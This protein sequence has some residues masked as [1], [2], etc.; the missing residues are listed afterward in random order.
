MP[1][2]ANRVSTRG[3]RSRE[4]SATGT[5]G[6][7]LRE[8]RGVRR[9]T[10]S[11]TPRRSRDESTARRPKDPF[12]MHD[13]L[14]AASREARRA[15]RALRGALDR[16]H[17][18]ELFAPLSRVVDVRTGLR[19]GGR[20]AVRSVAPGDLGP[21]GRSTAAATRD[22]ARRWTRGS[23]AEGSRPRDGKDFVRAMGC[24]PRPVSSL[25][26]RDTSRSAY[27][28][29]NA[30]HSIRGTRNEVLRALDLHGSLGVSSPRSGPRW[31]VL[32][33]AVRGP[34]PCRTPKR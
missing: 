15:E 11:N 28:P 26:P 8:C 10:S 5:H 4:S 23:S 31:E 14:G 16:L 32:P 19:R 29:S 27:G 25:Q 7:M 2:C 1:D 21:M 3:S 18:G 9:M 6:S 17:D 13:L 24:R 33:A 34:T 20:L 22:R 30:L 12:P